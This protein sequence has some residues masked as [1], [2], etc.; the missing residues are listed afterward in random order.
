MD[1]KGHGFNGRR[2]TVFF[3]HQDHSLLGREGAMHSRSDY[4]GGVE[5]LLPASGAYR[6]INKDIYYR[7]INEDI[8]Y[9][10]INE[11]IYYRTINKDIYYRTINEDIYY[12]TINEDIY[13]RTINKDIYYSPLDI[14]LIYVYFSFENSRKFSS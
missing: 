14:G 12:R 1:R 6:T 3:F 10:T 8:Y 4:W 7:T 13:Y 11:D 5:P 9:R 2:E